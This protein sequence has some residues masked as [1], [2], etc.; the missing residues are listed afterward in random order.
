MPHTGA[1]TPAL[2]SRGSWTARAG[3]VDFANG[4]SWTQQGG[5]LSGTGLSGSPATMASKH[6]ASGG[7]KVVIWTAQDGW[8]GRGNT[9]AGWVEMNRAVSE[10]TRKQKLPRTR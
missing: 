4:N 2:V 9:V 10:Q 7:C 3:S 8:C 1:N 6:A 5:T